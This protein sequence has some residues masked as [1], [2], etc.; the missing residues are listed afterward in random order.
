M[1]R[2][3]VGHLL[4]GLGYGDDTIENFRRTIINS[5]YITVTNDEAIIDELCLI[6]VPW[7]SGQY[8]CCIYTE[9]IQKVL[10]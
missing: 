4:C 7:L 6:G 10:Y 3:D 1:D 8:S 2:M 5:M 9:V